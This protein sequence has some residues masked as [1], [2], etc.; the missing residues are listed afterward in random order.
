MS[1]VS[2]SFRPFRSIPGSEF[3]SIFER[4]PHDQC[5]LSADAEGKD[6][7]RHTPSTENDLLNILKFFRDYCHEKYDD[8]FERHEECSL[9]GWKLD[10][11]YFQK[12]MTI[13]TET[14]PKLL[15]VKK[16]AKRIQ[17]LYRKQN[18][19]GALQSLVIYE[20]ARSFFE[21]YLG[22]SI[23]GKVG[24]I[25]TVAFV[26]GMINHYQMKLLPRKELPPTFSSRTSM[27]NVVTTTVTASIV[28]ELFKSAGLAQIIENI[29]V[30][31]FSMAGLATSH[32]AEVDALFSVA[33]TKKNLL[34]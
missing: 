25:F 22:T 3:I 24:H 14:S 18:C 19:I 34:F 10:L 20:V 28:S 23:L 26:N 27:L 31:N 12:K 11:I 16:D 8:K 7:V 29:T 32:K 30:N 13:T 6:N 5:P 21:G 17:A 2:S 15:D 4:K 33:K 9:C 1:A